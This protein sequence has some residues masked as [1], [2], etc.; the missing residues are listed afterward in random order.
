MP[1]RLPVIPALL[2]MLAAAGCTR[3]AGLFSEENARAHVSMLAGTI[4]SRPVGTEANAR[5]RAYVVDQLKLYGYDVR[6][7]EIDARR[8]ELGRTAHVSNIIGVLG[9]ERAEAIGLVSHYD[10]APES[11]GGADDGSGVAVTLEAARVLAARTDRKWSILVLVTDG[12]EAGLMGAAGVVTDREVMSRLKVYINTEAIGSRGTAVLFQAGP[13]NG[14]V[15]RPWARHAPHPRG[16]SFAVEVYKRLPNDTDFTILAREN[17][18]GLNFASID[19]SYAY[20]TARDTADRLSPASL[21]TTGENA[22]ATAAALDGLDITART[23]WDSVFFDLDRVTAVSYSGIA[24]WFLAATSIVLGVIAWLR[25]TAAALRIGGGWRWTFTAIRTALGAAL[26]TAAMIGAVWA[27]R[28]AREV[29]H[30]WYA[31]PNRMFLLLVAVGATVGWTMSR[32]G[33]WMP[34]RLR[35]LRH[36]IVTWSLALPVWLAMSAAMLWLAPGAAFLW[37]VPLLVASALLLLIQLVRWPG[38]SAPA[39]DPASP[40]I[41]IISV[42]VLGVTGALWLHNVADLLRFAVAMFGR[43]PIVTPIYV[44][45]AVIV[46]AAIMVVPPFVA[47]IATPRPLL[48]PS[49]LSAVCLLSIAIAAGFAYAAPAY[50]YEQP[51][52]RQVRALQEADGQIATWEVGSVEPGLDLGPG[53]PGGWTRQSGAAS[54]S[55]PWGRLPHP[56]VFRVSG[57]ALG[58]PPIDLAGFTVTPVAAGTEVTLTVVPRRTGLAI[59][60]VLPAGITPARSSLAGALRLG[61]WTAAFIAPPAE[62]IAWR[63]SFAGV[64][65]A[66]LREIRVAVTDSGFPGGTGPQRLPAWLPQERTVWSAAA[67]WVVPAGSAAPLEPVAAL[68]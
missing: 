33:A 2:V 52:R 29:Y 54:T 9:G 28:A 1:L 49:L 51:L 22:V 12:E 65:P 10:S 40:P 42:L 13:A 11:P 68:R 43:L 35:G 31:R 62:G 20:H 24:G 67:T 53:A 57:P 46:V 27:L 17:I 64:N 63:A 23:K 58:A 16:A 7:Q 37:T 30:P 45:P 59:S 21:R 32:A 18:P 6:V 19:D 25:I 66:R 56:F 61:H 48:R 44:Y 55:V 41:R 38:L 8:P 50:T 26:T 47:A 34:G 5:A 4:G 14:W 36:P 3:N 15:T 39:S 60:F